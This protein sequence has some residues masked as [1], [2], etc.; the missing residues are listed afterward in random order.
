MKK[1]LKI[2]AGFVA[3]VVIIAVGIFTS[4]KLYQNH[5]DKINHIGKVMDSYKGVKVYYNGK[6]YAES[7]GKNYS[8]DGYYYGYKWQCVEYIKRFYYEAK[9]HSMPNG[10]GN[11]KDFFD[12]KV[13]QGKLNKDRGLFQYKNGENE[14]PKADDILVF[15][16]TKYGHVVIVTKVTDD[17][18][19]VIQQNMGNKTRD[20]FKLEYENGKYFV[21]GKRKPKG[22]LRK[23]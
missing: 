18:V 10:F 8:K 22:W 20:Q 9:G 11:A 13:G 6:K 16:D 3:V 14:K 17:T 4:R 19:E 1:T 21:C 15:T 2:L 23:G 7:H 5:V 12:P